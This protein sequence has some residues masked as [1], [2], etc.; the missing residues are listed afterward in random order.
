MLPE[1][2]NSQGNLQII[3]GGADDIIINVHRGTYLNI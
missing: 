2:L 3:K 1:D